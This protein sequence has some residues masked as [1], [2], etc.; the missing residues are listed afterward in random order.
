MQDWE[1]GD[2]DTLAPEL[3]GDAQPTPSCDV[4]SLGATIYEL[5]TGEA[6]CARVCF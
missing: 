1:E 4:F 6:P 3:L 5:A 2:G